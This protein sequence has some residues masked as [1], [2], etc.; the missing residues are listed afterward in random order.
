MFIF[1]FFYFDVVCALSVWLALM[2]EAVV[3]RDI[4]A[5]KNVWKGWAVFL[6]G[7]YNIQL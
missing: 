4:L 1:S 3:N 2:P 6:K 7:L 5:I